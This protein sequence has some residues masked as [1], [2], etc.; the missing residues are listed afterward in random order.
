M[1]NTIVELIFFG[2]FVATL[3]CCEILA[4]VAADYGMAIAV[5]IFRII[6]WFILLFGGCSL[7]YYIYTNTRDY[8]F[9]LWGETHSQEPSKKEETGKKKNK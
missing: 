5:V 1:M 7:I 2:A 8:I 4:R 9:K 6:A 3:L